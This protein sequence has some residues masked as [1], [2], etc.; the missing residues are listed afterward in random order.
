[1]VLGEVGGARVFPLAW[2][3]DYWNYLDWVDPF[4]DA[5]FTERQE[6]VAAAIGQSGLYTPEMLINLHEMT[7]TVATSVSDTTEV[8]DYCLGLEVDTS[9][10]V[11]LGS[12]P[13]AS[14][15]LV[16]YMTGGAPA[17]SELTIVLAEGGLE[18]QITG[19]ENNGST[20]AHESV[21]RAFVTIVD[22]LELGSAELAVPDDLV[23]ANARI[24]AFVQDTE[25]LEYHGATGI[26]LV[27]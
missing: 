1:V 21:V 4:S 5:A 15:L 25:S 13:D 26:P 22:D 23:S 20:L 3:V 16:N 14:P 27:E 2:H 8:I 18:S 12:A 9:V 6:R 11:W 19:G 7:Y 17:G 24:V 10:T